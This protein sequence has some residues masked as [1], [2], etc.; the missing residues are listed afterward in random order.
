VKLKKGDNIYLQKLADNF[1]N[2]LYGK[3]DKNVFEIKDILVDNL[4]NFFE[5]EIVSFK[6]VYSKGDLLGAYTGIIKFA[7]SSTIFAK[8]SN[9]KPTTINNTLIETEIYNKLPDGKFGPSLLKSLQYPPSLFLTDLSECTWCP[10]WNDDNLNSVLNQIEKFS[11]LK[12]DNLE[13]MSFHSSSNCNW[14]KTKECCENLIHTKYVTLDWIEKNIN[15]ILEAYDPKLSFGNYTVHGDMRSHNLCIDNGV[16][17]FIDFDK[18]KLG[19]KFHD[20]AFLLADIHLEGGIPPE[21][22][23]PNRSD[24]AV[25]VCGYSAFLCNHGAEHGKKLYTNRLRTNLSW[26]IRALKLTPADGEKAN[27]LLN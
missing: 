25:F 23:M 8:I 26:M 21:V 15:K 7:D 4:K 19:D 5:K 16:T 17:K 14:I 22:F 11:E 10:E 20:L 6:P 24:Y 1:C 13:D 12:I 3:K 9:D 2:D 27:L 18:V